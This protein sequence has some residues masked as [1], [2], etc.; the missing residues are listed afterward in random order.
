[1]PVAGPVA[2]HVDDA[3]DQKERMAM[4]QQLEDVGGFRRPQL[5]LKTLSQ[6][7]NL[8][9]IS[10]PKR[11]LRSSAAALSSLGYLRIGVELIRCNHYGMRDAGRFSCSAGWP[12]RQSLPPT[13]LTRPS[14]SLCL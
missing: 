13:P 12:L 14:P 4:R 7:A 3:V 8:S 1:M 10:L 9:T 11:I 2:I 5:G 6:E